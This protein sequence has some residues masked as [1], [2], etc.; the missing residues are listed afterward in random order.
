MDLTGLV[1]M[2]EAEV[3]YTVIEDYGLEET[4]TKTM[5]LKRVF[6]ATLVRFF[7]YN[8]SLQQEAE[9]SLINSTL[10]REIISGTRLWMLSFPLSWL[11]WG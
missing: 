11:I 8:G 10:K 9:E 3:N 4:G 1:S 5:V 6:F 7:I 2:R